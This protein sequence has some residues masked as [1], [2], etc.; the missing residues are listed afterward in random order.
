[1]MDHTAPRRGP[2]PHDWD[3]RNR[4]LDVLLA[5]VPRI[6]DKAVEQCI[7]DDGTWSGARALAAVVVGFSGGNDSIV[8]ADVMRRFSPYPFSFV[9][10]NTGIG[11]EATREFVRKQC[12]EWGIPLIER[13]PPAGSTYRER[14]LQE[15]FPGPAS[16]S[17][18]FN[19]IKK[20][21]ME[22]INLELVGNPYKHRVLWV[23]GRRYTESERRRQR[24]IKPWERDTGIK[25]M[26][27]CSPIRGWTGLDLLTYR[28]R[29]R[30]CPR[31]P[32]ADELEMSG[33]CLC[34]CNAKKGELDYLDSFPSSRPAVQ[35][36]RDLERE[37]RQVALD[38]GIPLERCRWGWG[39]Y[40]SRQ[41]GQHEAA[42]VGTLCS[43]DCGLKSFTWD[44]AN[45]QGAQ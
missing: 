22:A 13:T 18:T 34:G 1:M 33:E 25:S 12:A 3:A 16:H 8:L 5:S 32:V 11:V 21:A 35:E 45:H 4:R 28:H 41:R 30:D 7:A 17:V 39:A 9:H 10:A 44:D 27:W 20:R 40:R 37:V 38:R 6:L 31:N 29:Y 19:R 24:K 43:S 36:I 14:V 26:V 15:G 42:T 2:A 23:A